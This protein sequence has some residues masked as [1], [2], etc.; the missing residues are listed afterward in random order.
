MRWLVFNY[1]RSPIFLGKHHL[2]NDVSDLLMSTILTIGGVFPNDKSWLAYCWW[3]TKI[4]W[5][6]IIHLFP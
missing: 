2:A 5:H 4:I 3:H 6:Y 1:F